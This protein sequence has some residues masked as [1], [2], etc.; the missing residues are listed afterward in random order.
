MVNQD[1]HKKLIKGF[2]SLTFRKMLLDLI[3]F[4]T[5]YVVVAKH[6]SIETFGIFA[7]ASIILGIFS[8]FS[9]IGFG[10]AIIQKKVLDEDDVKTTFFIQETL[11]I[12]IFIVVWFSAPL[13]ADFYNF[14]NA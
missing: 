9:D 13:F 14:D 7:I 6:V 5:I 1:I 8:Y 3:N 11:S 10:A 2:L 12:L 4:V